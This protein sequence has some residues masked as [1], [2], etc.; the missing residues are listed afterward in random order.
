MRGIFLAE[1]GSVYGGVHSECQP[2]VR[3]KTWRWPKFDSST[4]LTNPF[5]LCALFAICISRQSRFGLNA[6]AGAT[7]QGV[8]DWY[9]RLSYGF[10]YATLA[11]GGPVP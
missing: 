8:S 6:R 5:L 11:G 1:T 3:L 10:Q 4:N 7:W 9:D 2:A